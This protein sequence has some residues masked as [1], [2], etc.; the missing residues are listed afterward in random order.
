MPTLN[1]LREVF[2]DLADDATVADSS[3]LRR[4]ES[5]I[6]P[7]EL[8]PANRSDP[9]PR[10]RRILVTGR[11]VA[12]LLVAALLVAALTVLP[13]L[14]RTGGHTASGK[15]P[16]AVCTPAATYC[17]TA[18]GVPWS[19]TLRVNGRL[20]PFIG[21]EVS[22][23]PR[24]VAVAVGSRMTFTLV[25]RHRPGVTVRNVYLFAFPGAYSFRGSRPIG[26]IRV[27]GRHAGA[28][29]SGQTMSGNWMATPIDG[30]RHLYVGVSFHVGSKNNEQANLTKLALTTPH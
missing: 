4:A 7:I 20:A 3:D 30:N 14:L 27:L 29:P 9:R 24:S 21:R 12:A 19:A 18:V 17:F 13:S 8:V 15:A 16:D 25:L 28:L 1:D 22:R 26:H 5:A 2:R 11:V 6:E 10:G 23:P